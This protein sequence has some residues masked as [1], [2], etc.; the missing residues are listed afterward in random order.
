MLLRVPTIVM[1]LPRFIMITSP[2]DHKFDV[3]RKVR[4]LA[5]YAFNDPFFCTSLPVR[6]QRIIEVDLVAN[7]IFT[8]CHTNRHGKG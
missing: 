8:S 7:L 5:L 4:S 3:I 6:F 1:G 2:T